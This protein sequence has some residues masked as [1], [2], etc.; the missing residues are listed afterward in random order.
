MS[1]EVKTTAPFVKGDTVRC[2]DPGSCKTLQYGNLYEI[3]RVYGDGQTVTVRGSHGVGYA[4]HRFEKVEVAKTADGQSVVV[5]DVITD[6]APSYGVVVLFADNRHQ[7]YHYVCNIPEVEVDDY[8]IV[9]DKRHN[10]MDLGIA[11]VTEIFELGQ[12]S[13]T[14][15]IL[16]KADDG[17]YFRK[18]RTMAKIDDL[19]KRARE[20]VRRV[21]QQKTLEDVLGANNPLLLELKALKDSL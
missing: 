13:A 14:I 7:T 16:A 6:S 5:Q 21:Q 3:Q 19:E 8:V 12:K 4:S 1:N 18:K 17:G 9:E 15:S 11:K 10:H 20:E 2:I